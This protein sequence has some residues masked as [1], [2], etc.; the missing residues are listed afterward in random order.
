MDSNQVVAAMGYFLSVAGFVGLL[1]ERASDW[2]TPRW[3]SGAR[4][5]GLVLGAIAWFA[6]GESGSGRLIGVTGGIPEQY[7]WFAISGIVGG[8]LGYW[9]FRRYISPRA[10]EK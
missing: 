8:I 1:C 7:A 2:K 10:P 4:A 3:G 9:I 5:F 6:I